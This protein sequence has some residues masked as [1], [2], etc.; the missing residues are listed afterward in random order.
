MDVHVHAA[1]TEQLRRRGVD[2]LTA[3]D[4]GALH[5]PD[6]L[7]LERSTAAGRVLFTH[8][9]RFKALAEDWQRRGN[10]FAGLLWGHPMRLT[11]GRMVIELELIAKASDP[12]DWQNV[13]EV[14]PL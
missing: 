13:V 11:I 10:P 14:L 8:D 2:F 6:R 3:Q 5:L 4:D 7:L 9:I 12:M 1:V